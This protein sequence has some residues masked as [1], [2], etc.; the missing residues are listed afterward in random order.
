MTDRQRLRLGI[1]AIFK[2]EA[3]YILEWVA[4]HRVLGFDRFFIADNNSD[5]GSTELLASLDAAGLVDHIPF[6][7]VPTEPPQLAAYS[8]IISRHG[9][10]ADWMAFIDADEFLLPTDGTRSLV[11]FFAG[12][13][14]IPEIGAVALNW[15]T[16]GSSGHIEATDDLVIERFV[17]R[18]DR[19]WHTNH[20]YKMAV[21]SAA[22]PRTRGTP[23]HFDVGD[24]YEKVQGNGM[25]LATH[26]ERGE[27]LSAEV[28]WERV[29]INHY[30]VKSRREFFDRKGPK[31][32]AT[33]VGATK[34]ENYYFSHDRN[35][36]K[37]PVPDWL[38][39]ATK[40]E[41]LR[42][43]RLLS[44]PRPPGTAQS[45]VAAL[46]P[47]TVERAPIV[48]VRPCN[49]GNQ[50]FR[51]ML[52][53]R[54][55]DEVP[56]AILAGVNLPEWGL[57]APSEEPGWTN[58][59]RLPP[60]H[61]IDVHKAASLLRSGANDGVCVDALAQRLEYFGN[62]RERFAEVFHSDEPGEPV[63]DDEIAIS[64]RAGDIMSGKHPDY[65]PLPIAYYRHI[66]RDTGLSPVF[67][68]QLDDSP[69]VSALRSAFPAAR[70]I[71]NPHWL[72]DFQSVRNARNIAIA[73][74]SFSWLAGW[75][76]SRANR[77]IMP[78]AGYFNPRQRPDVDLCPIGDARYEFYEFPVHRFQGI[79]AELAALLAPHAD[80]RALSH[81][82]VARLKSPRPSGGELPAA[83]PQPKVPDAPAMPAA[84][85]A[86]LS[87]R[88]RKSRCYLEY[89]SGGSTIQA[90]RSGIGTIV[91]VESD[92]AWLD[93]VRQRLEDVPGRRTLHLMLADIGPTKAL[94][95]PVTDAGWQK[96]SSYP[97][98]AWQRCREAS[99]APDLVLVDGRF[100]VA[101]CLA[102]F[103]FARP[104]CRVLLDDY[105]ER[106]HYFEVE[107]YV[108]RSK[109]I[110]RMAEFIV[111]RWLPRDEVWLAFVKATTD[112]R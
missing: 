41:M 55:A 22:R 92:R 8:E 32:R 75:L 87:E 40:A 1:G 78:L 9:D 63:R 31:G 53:A 82:A 21:R 86:Y 70:F 107:K 109:T 30:V 79:D 80:F 46:P 28:N 83:P 97:L 67:V 110:G 5:D 66:V 64:I 96:Y 103:L 29:R 72:R 12:L 36:V 16:Y 11:P 95:Y 45:A 57:D 71:R 7:H 81:E 98:G 69:Y 17:R 99:L 2:N 88:M 15:A 25:R 111:P 34:G 4:Y 6:P 60:V 65:T 106:P 26:P 62:G 68:G 108:R 104:G 44:V 20:H 3:P 85:V 48:Y 33:V 100:R 74:S 89:G 76:S 50:M 38:L 77:I 10:D 101:C 13:N 61:V 35:E 39:E 91:A 94:G 18:G 51:Y 14:A 84:E 73:V 24:G 19:I 102:T 90:A 49:V 105:L 112:P 27:G 93:M 37:D 23:H 58:P 56:G 47:G 54:I 52:A 42:L 59:L 43:R